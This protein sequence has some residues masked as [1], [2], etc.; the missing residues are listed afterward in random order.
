[1]ATSTPSARRSRSTCPDVE[2]SPTYL[3]VIPVHDEQDSLRELY[4][5][6]DEV[7][8]HLDGDVEVLFVDDG[9]TDM[10]YPLMLELHHRDPRFK[11]VHLA[12][13]FGHQLAITAGIELARGDAVVVMD[14][15]LQH[16]PELLPELAARWREGYDVV[17]GVM[18]E[19]PEGWV[20]RI[21]ARVYYRLLRKLTTIEIPAAAGD[22]RL[23]DRRVIDAFRAMPERNRFVRGMFA[24]LGHR[25]IA[26]PYAVPERFAGSS[27]YTLRRMIRLA[28]D[29]LVSFSTAPLRLALDLGFVVSAVAFLFGI[30]T[31]ITKLAGAFL[32]PGWLT[33]VLVTSFI[34]GIQL[35]VIGVVGEHVGR[36]YDEAKA[37]LH[38]L[39]CEPHGFDHEPEL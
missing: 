7:F 17:Y 21:T 36:I 22:F 39:G 10:S 35:I 29:G 18:T 6:L 28:T 14:G 5:R 16:P 1:M 15:D 30:A 9:S 2:P 4:R 19:R 31:L 38:Y 11:V 33:I 3:L 37:R 20:K 25:Q 26:V 34:G 12:R 23:A 24:W 8:P 13:N 27:K 32:V